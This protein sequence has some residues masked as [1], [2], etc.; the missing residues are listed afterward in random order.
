MP[1][2]ASGSGPKP[3]VR[4]E[5][6]RPLSGSMQPARIPAAARSDE[7]QVEPDL[8][9]QAG[10]VPRLHGFGK[11]GRWV[12]QSWSLDLAAEKC[13][14]I[15]DPVALKPAPA[16]VHG[17]PNKSGRTVLDQTGEPERRRNH[18]TVRTLT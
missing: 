17:D 16:G 18:L 12:S 8:H 13:L 11:E 2:R 6:W 7:P 3:L 15:R 4:K 5:S 14:P 10:P 9:Y 1:L